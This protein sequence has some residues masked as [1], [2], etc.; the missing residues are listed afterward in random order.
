MTSEPVVELRD[1][2]K[3]FGPVQALTDV[4][5]SLI[6]GQVHCLAGE[7]GAG[8]STLIRVLTGALRRDDGT[9]EIDGEPVTAP[10]PASVRAAGVQA[11]Y[12]EL[13]LLPHL[14]VAENLFMGRLPARTGIITRSRC[15]T[16]PGRPSTR[17]A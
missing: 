15:A 14:S 13:S 10:T 4:S 8:K 6:P 11:V 16:V 5:L 1:V 12:Q 7:N 17:S 9:Y 3:A 2:S